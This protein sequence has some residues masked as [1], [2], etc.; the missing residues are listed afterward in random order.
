M[1][2]AFWKYHGTGNDFILIDN[3]DGLFPVSKQQIAQWC[4]R[5]FGI[6]ADGLILLQHDAE[7]DFRMVYFN[8]DGGESTM[9]GNGGRCVVQFASDLGM[10][11]HH[12]RFR[13]I[14]G[15]HEADLTNGIITLHM[16]DVLAWEK[17]PQGWFLDTG[18]PHLVSVESALPSK[19]YVV[20]QGRAWRHL[21]VFEPGGTNVNFMVS[22]PEC[23]EVRTYERGV[24]DETLSCGTGVVASVLADFLQLNPNPAAFKGER[25]VNVQGGELVVRFQFVDD[26]PSLFTGIQLIGP[27]VRVFQGEMTL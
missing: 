7:C 16:K 11:S 14:D 9:C 1:K 13:A 3:R 17:L 27:A 18:S 22:H 12:T 20:N 19:E 24:E 5:R 15:F 2:V 6:G 23:I 4:D 25:R 21:P 10:I 26:Q 8:A